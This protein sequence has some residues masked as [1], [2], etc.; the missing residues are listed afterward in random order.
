MARTRE[1]FPT[2]EI[3]HKWAHQT[4]ACARNPQGNLRFTG[5][6]ITSYSADIAQIYKK[7]KRPSVGEN[8]P[9]PLLN[10]TVRAAHEGKTLVLIST[11][12]YSNTTARQ[13]SRIARA[14]QHLPHIYV[15][16][17]CPRSYA[18]KEAHAKN[19]AFLVKRHA[20]AL[21][22]AKRA[23]SVAVVA[24]RRGEGA[25]ALEDARRYAA[26]FAIRRALPAFPAAEWQAAEERAQRIENP[27]PE[28]IARREKMRAQRDATSEAVAEYRAEMARSM[29]AAG[30]FLSYRAY[31]GPDWK[32]TLTRLAQSP[33]DKQA[34]FLRVGCQRSAWRLGVSCDAREGAIMLRVNGEQIETSQGARIPLVAAPLVWAAV[35]RAIRKGGY[36]PSGLGGMKIGDYAVTRI[37]ADGTLEVGCHTIPHSELRAMA[38][39]LNIS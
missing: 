12:R 4:Q 15:P 36:V 14:V 33:I 13:V 37:G 23:Q 1:V 9:G 35:Q 10:A 6:V 7:G 16:E 39:A 32:I 18:M 30:Y 19:L 25:Q 17:P 3:P 34:E 2:A 24:W 11:H 29:Q 8:G 20:D 27:S 21:A 5:N 31:R 28:E 22:K 26:F 38:R